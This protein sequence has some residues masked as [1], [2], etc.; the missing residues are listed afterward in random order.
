[1]KGGARERGERE[2]RE[3]GKKEKK[4]LRGLEIGTGNAEM[5]EK[6]R[7]WRKFARGM[8]VGW[9]CRVYRC[10]GMLLFSSTCY[11]T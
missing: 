9:Y 11:Q 3:G 2:K 10:S 1:M 7:V 8:N 4:M 6:G 5:W